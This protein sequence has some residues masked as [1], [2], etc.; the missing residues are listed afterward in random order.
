MPYGGHQSLR[1]CP[2][3]AEQLA[4]GCAA[5]SVEGWSKSSSGDPGSCVFEAAGGGVGPGRGSVC[6]GSFS[7]PQ[8]QPRAPPPCPDLSSLGPFL[9]SFPPCKRSWVGG[10]DKQRPS[11]HI[12]FLPFTLWPSLFFLL[13]CIL[14]GA[15]QDRWPELGWEKPCLYTAQPRSSTGFCRV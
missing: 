9:S 1:L 11:I 7:S 12:I 15:D 4:R 5:A 13:L 2:R 8:G 10:R 3:S 14:M 6:P